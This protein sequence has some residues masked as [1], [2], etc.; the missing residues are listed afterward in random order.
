MEGLTLGV[1]QGLWDPGLSCTLKLNYHQECG[2]CDA[3]DSRTITSSR[4]PGLVLGP[5]WEEVACLGRAE[6][7]RPVSQG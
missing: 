4:Q 7:R 3:T 2:H 6:D 1:S 5:G